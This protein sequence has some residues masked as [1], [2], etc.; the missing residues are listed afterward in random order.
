MSGLTGI[1]ETVA[2][3]IGAERPVV[4][5][6]VAASGERTT[7]TIEPYE[8]APTGEGHLIVRAMDR[9]S[10]MPRSFRL[11][12]IAVASLAGGEFEVDRSTYQ[13]QRDA[14]DRIR[15][16]IADVAPGGWYEDAMRW[17][18][19]DALSL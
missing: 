15:E 13:R 12:R 3:A 11:D 18:P 5:T 19:G 14:L 2:F 17:T 6:Y 1:D 16:E 10:G 8:F 9:R 4:I 7:R